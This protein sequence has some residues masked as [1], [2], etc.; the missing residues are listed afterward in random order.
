MIFLIKIISV[1]VNHQ[2]IAFDNFDEN[3]CVL[4]WWKFLNG[5]LS[6]HLLGQIIIITSQQGDDEDIT[7]CYY[8]LHQ[9]LSGTTQGFLAEQ[10]WDLENNFFSASALAD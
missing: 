9:K 2:P 7:T 1:D 5:S 4:L 10:N 8:G 3:L 6:S